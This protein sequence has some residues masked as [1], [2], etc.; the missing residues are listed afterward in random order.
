V[1]ERKERR[2]ARRIAVLDPVRA[3]AGSTLALIL[4]VTAEGLRVVHGGHLARVGDVF[5][6]VV[7]W[8]D[9]RILLR[10]EVRRTQIRQTQEN[11]ASRTLFESGLRIVHAEEP[12]MEVYRTLIAAGRNRKRD[13]VLV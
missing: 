11:D 4:D 12:S 13:A 7:D 2:R 9:Q 5:T 8:N 6:L 10:C 3:R 1:S